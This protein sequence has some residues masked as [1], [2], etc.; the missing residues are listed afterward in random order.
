M[1][2]M[3]K[4]IFFMALATVA[5][6]GCKQE[7]KLNPDVPFVE[8]EVSF[9]GEG[10]MYVTTDNKALENST[11]AWTAEETTITVNLNM[12]VSDMIAGSWE[13]GH[14]ELP[15]ADINEFL[16]Y[17][18]SD[19]DETTFVAYNPDG[20][21]VKEMTSYKPG[22]WITETGLGQYG[23][24]CWQW[25]IWGDKG[26]YYDDGWD[27]YKCRFYVVINPGFDFS[28][29]VGQTVTSKCVITCNDTNYDFIVN[30][31]IAE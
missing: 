1:K 10:V 6:L 15:T 5:L 19:L 16:E 26:V 29:L 18:V 13:F 21:K 9:N 31:N 8:R 11:F 14:F 7:M 24:L 4:K 3:K 2:I 20:S 30:F 25:N 22:M 12:S 23:V 28:T 27:A 17:F